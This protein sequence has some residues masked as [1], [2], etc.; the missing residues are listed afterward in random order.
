MLQRVARM[1]ADLESARE[2]ARTIHVR[3]IFLSTNEVANIPPD[4]GVPRQDKVQHRLVVWCEVEDG[5]CFCSAWMQPIDW[6]WLFTL[7]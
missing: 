2:R 5:V 6:V 3:S 1:Y 7:Q 4:R